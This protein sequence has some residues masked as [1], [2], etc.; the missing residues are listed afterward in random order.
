M[1]S[2]MDFSLVLIKLENFINKY[3]TPFHGIDKFNRWT[4]YHNDKHFDIGTRKG[5]IYA[6]S[7]AIGKCGCKNQSLRPVPS[8]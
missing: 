4:L 1:Q 6:F 7:I 5:N 8:F 2:H 3:G